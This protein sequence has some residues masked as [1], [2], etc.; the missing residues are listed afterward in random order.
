MVLGR[1]RGNSEPATTEMM[2]VG[3]LI[4]EVVVI[5]TVTMIRIVV[6]I[7]GIIIIDL[8]DNAV[9]L[10]KGILLIY[11]LDHG[12][13]GK[14]RVRFLKRTLLPVVQWTS[15]NVSLWPPSSSASVGISVPMRKV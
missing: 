2:V 9:L 7:I 3:I 4:L 12:I 5:V 10:V 11:R 1:V 15:S 14:K 13:H 8:V 6:M